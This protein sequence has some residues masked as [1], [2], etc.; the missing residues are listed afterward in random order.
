[1]DAIETIL[2]SAVDD[3]ILVKRPLHVGI[4]CAMRT[5]EI[6]GLRW[7]AFRGDYFLIRDTAWRGKLLEDATKTGNEW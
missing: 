1:L 5:A 4:F 7:S 3:D 6:F 2:E